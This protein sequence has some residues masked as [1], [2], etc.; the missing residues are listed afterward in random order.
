M[1]VQRGHNDFQGDH[2]VN[3]TFKVVVEDVA[4]IGSV[5][6]VIRQAGATAI[7]GVTFTIVDA[8]D[9]RQ[10]AIATA[11]R[12]AVARAR[13]IAEASGH[14]LGRMLA[15]GTPEAL[16]AFQPAAPERHSINDMAMHAM[17][18]PDHGDAPVIGPN[19]VPAPLTVQAT[20]H[21]SWALENASA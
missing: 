17:M 6:D 15:L 8:E 10:E 7:L 18:S 14:R 4:T 16:A 9:A 1:I 21:G 5:V 20:V 2:F 13:T 19:I 12:I 11:T 3:H